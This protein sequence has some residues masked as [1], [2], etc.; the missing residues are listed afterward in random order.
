MKKFLKWLVYPKYKIGEVM[1]SL[2]LVFVASLY[3]NSWP[4]LLTQVIVTCALGA[5][6]IFVVRV[7]LRRALDVD[8]ITRKSIQFIGM[9]LILGIMLTHTGWFDRAGIAFSLPG[10]EAA[11]TTRFGLFISLRAA[12]GIFFIVLVLTAGKLGVDR[13]MDV[14]VRYFVNIPD[15]ALQRKY[16]LLP[17]VAAIVAVIVW[18][19]TQSLADGLIYGILA[20][21]VLHGVGNA[22]LMR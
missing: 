19:N 2:V 13:L 22:K 10:I 1:I 9:A 14:G 15:V 3:L 6:I 12:V 16:R 4:N 20:L 5:G 21:D 8:T 17:F 18:L 7:I 11:F